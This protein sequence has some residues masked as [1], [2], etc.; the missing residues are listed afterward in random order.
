M[1][2]MLIAIL[3]LPG[4]RKKPEP[5]EPVPEAPGAARAVPTPVVLELP[6][7]NSVVGVTLT[8]LPEH[9]VASYSGEGQMMFA[10]RANPIARIFVQ[11]DPEAG[12]LDPAR[13]HEQA[14][15]RAEL[16]G[17]GQQT[18]TG[19][20]PE[21]PFGTAAWSASHYYM[22]GSYYDQVELVSPHP[23]G[24]GVLRLRAPYPEGQYEPTAKV[25]ELLDLLP[26]VLPVADYPA[27]HAE[28]RAAEEGED[29]EG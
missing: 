20:V 7:T 4:C 15:I 9:L 13:Y 28:Y 11:S 10:E 6:M 5:V 3:S 29:E 14:R 2:S 17:G 24:T 8:S 25:A 27:A 1:L 19:V 12:A 21:A 16:F 18:A 22:D 23:E 26:R